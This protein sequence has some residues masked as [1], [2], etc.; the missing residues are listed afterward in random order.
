MTTANPNR[1]FTGKVVLVTGSGR[2][3][4]AATVLR[5]AAAGA[6]VIVNDIEG[7]RARAVAAEVEA[8]GARVLLSTH[9]VSQHGAALDLVA[10]ARARFGT[11]HVLVNNAGITRDALLHKLDEDAWDEVIR[12]N[13][14]GPFNVGKACARLMVEQRWGRIVNI[15]SLAWLGNVGQSNYASSKA[16]V[17]GLTRTW[18][19]E[20]GRY[21]ITVNAVAPGFIDSVLTRQV[22]PAIHEKYVRKIPIGRIGVPEDIARAVTFLASEDAA[23]VSGQ[24]LHVDGA[25]SVGIAGAWY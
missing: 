5:F 19:L 18:A 21:G 6:D 8:I 13:L 14:K 4:G 15:A 17:V 1:P 22:P 2:G 9:D 23:Y 24:C 3:L 10:A 11:V 25:L 16:G 12:V 7:D 20:L